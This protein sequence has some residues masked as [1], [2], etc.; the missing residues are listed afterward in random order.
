MVILFLLL[1]DLQPLDISV[2]GLYKALIRQEFNSWYSSEVERLPEDDLDKVVDLRA[3]L[4][5]PF[6]ATWLIKTH[7]AVAGRK[8]DIIRGFVEAGILDKLQDSDDDFHERDTDPYIT[9]SSSE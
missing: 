9:S 5:K 1:G 3:S 6:N 4:I 2:N 8:S 7:G